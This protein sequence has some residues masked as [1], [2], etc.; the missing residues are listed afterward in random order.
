M[1]G[2]GMKLGGSCVPAGIHMGTPAWGVVLWVL[3]SVVIGAG[4][5]AGGLYW[6]NH[7]WPQSRGFT[8]ALYSELSVGDTGF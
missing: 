4:G 8:D 2:S 6:Y 5:L 1:A 7:G 3:G